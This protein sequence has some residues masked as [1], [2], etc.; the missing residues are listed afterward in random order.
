MHFKCSSSEDLGK[1]P[2]ERDNYLSKVSEAIF[3]FTRLHTRPDCAPSSAFGS[4]NAPGGVSRWTLLKV[5]YLAAA[6]TSSAAQNVAPAFL[7][8]D[9]ELR[10]A[11]SFEGEREVI[12]RQLKERL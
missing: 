5:S 2:Y 8:S 1:T 11:T 3:M 9:T 7:E 10:A 6:T 12:S 4:L